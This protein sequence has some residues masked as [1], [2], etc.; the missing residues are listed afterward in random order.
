MRGK[1]RSPY[2]ERRYRSAPGEKRMNERWR[3]KLERNEVVIVDGAMGSEL[4]RCGVPRDATAWS[5]L[6]SLTHAELV[7]EIHEAYV[8]AGADVLIAN[9]FATS[10]FV[11]EAAGHGSDFVRANRDAIALAQHAAAVREVAVA[12]SISNFPPAFDRTRYPDP[13]AELV[14]YREQAAL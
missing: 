6:A 4:L 2:F 13:V 8:Q 3:R 12:G 1:H 9:T 10:R 5:G 7:Q 11:L 14:A